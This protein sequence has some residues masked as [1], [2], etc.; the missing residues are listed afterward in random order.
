MIGVI[1]TYAGDAHAHLYLHGHVSSRLFTQATAGTLPVSACAT[2]LDGLVLSLTPFSHSMNYASACVFGKGGLVAD[3]EEK[4][5]ALERI[6]EKVLPGRWDNTRVPPTSAEMT[7]T[8]VLKVVIESASGKKREGGPSDERKDLKDEE[9]VERV[10]TGV[11]PMAELYQAP[12]RS[13]Y[14]RGTLPS[15]I[16]EYVAERNKEYEER[17]VKAAGVEYKSKA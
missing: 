9:V 14:C 3:A 4:M 15:Y 8:H 5:W 17:A 2:R 16:E 11:L 6:T 1:A 10:W 12:V 7:T 13:D